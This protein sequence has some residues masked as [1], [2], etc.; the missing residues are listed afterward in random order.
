MGIRVTEVYLL[1][2]FSWLKGWVSRR[3]MSSFTTWNNNVYHTC[4]NILYLL[5]TSIHIWCRMKICFVWLSPLILKCL[6]P[7]VAPNSWNTTTCY[8][9]IDTKILSLFVKNKT[10]SLFL[11]RCV[12][13]KATKIDGMVY[14]LILHLVLYY[15][16]LWWN[17]EYHK[18]Q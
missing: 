15:T 1:V 8:C 18:K 5:G 3:Q 2:P 6:E 4:G 14:F 12:S 10:I 7:R 13:I 17:L 9:K 16:P 11:T